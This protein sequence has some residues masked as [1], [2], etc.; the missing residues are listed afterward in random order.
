MHFIVVVHF[1]I[2]NSTIDII[3][4][5]FNYNHAS[6]LSLCV[7]GSFFF[8]V[9]LYFSISLYFSFVHSVL[10]C[11]FNGRNMFVSIFFKYIN[12]KYHFQCF[13]CFT[14]FVVKDDF[15]RRNLNIGLTIVYYV[16]CH[17]ERINSVVPMVC[18][19]VV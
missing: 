10:I 13:D 4:T 19:L 9:N 16:S 18:G 6:L 14:L 11:Y 12:K 7:L 1:T 15:S 3:I 5:T 2:D 17:T 8:G